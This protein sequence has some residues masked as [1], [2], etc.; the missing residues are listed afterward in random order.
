MWNRACPLC[1]VKV[2]R[3]SVLTHGD[4]L[5]CPSCHAPL[6]L[7]R[8]TR[9]FSAAVGL[10]V[11]Y[12]VANA[13]SGSNARGGWLWPI[14]GAVVGYAFGSASILYF[15]ADLTVR[16]DATANPFPQPRK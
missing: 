3:S 11:A 9:V 10:L 15:L 7:S 6:E 13:V 12:A 5:T 1:F 14:L 16:Q 2:P 4:Q 8:S